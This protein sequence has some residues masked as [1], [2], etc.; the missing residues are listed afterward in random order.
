MTGGR[1]GGLRDSAVVRLALPIFAVVATATSGLA[2]GACGD[3]DGGDAEAFCAEVA[4]NAEALRAD[5]ATDDDVDA[6]I[7]LWRDVGGDAPLEIEPEWTRLV[8]NL[9][10]AWTGEDQQEILASTFAAERSALG[11]AAWVAEHC[12]FDFGP[13]TTIVPGTLPEASLPAGASTS[14]TPPAT[15]PPT[16]P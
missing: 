6:L 10:L 13:V 1:R 14:T 16:T 2:L 3:D 12:G 15:T 5:P 9:E 8:D 7:D 4:D 11:V